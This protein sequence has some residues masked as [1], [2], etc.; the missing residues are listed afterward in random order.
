V[1]RLELA[2]QVFEREYA[3]LF[4]WVQGAVDLHSAA[5]IC[6]TAFSSLMWS[7]ASGRHTSKGA[8]VAL[9]TA[10]EAPLRRAIEARGGYLA[11]GAYKRALWPR[12]EEGLELAALYTTWVYVHAAAG[13]GPVERLAIST[14]LRRYF[15]DIL[16][17]THEGDTAAASDLIAQAA[18]PFVE[19]LDEA[20]PQ[21]P[22]AAALAREVWDREFYRSAQAYRARAS[23]TGGAADGKEQ[24]DHHSSHARSTYR[25]NL[26]AGLWHVRD[27]EPVAGARRAAEPSAHEHNDGRGVLGSDS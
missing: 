9:Y 22:H 4:A 7:G 13:M 17:M 2:R 25:V 3:R 16:A 14:G 15:P 19:L 12:Y 27:A 5:V 8:V 23:L 26:M 24:Q 18:R 11:A 20:A 6:Y 1:T 10:A 21:D